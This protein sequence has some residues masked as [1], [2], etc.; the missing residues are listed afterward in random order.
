LP[1]TIGSGRELAGNIGNTNIWYGNNTG[2]GLINN[3]LSTTSHYYGWTEAV[4][5]DMDTSCFLVLKFAG[6]S[7]TDQT[8]QFRVISSHTT[9]GDI[10]YT[11]NP[12]LGSNPSEAIVLTE[13]KAC[14]TGQQEF[15]TAVLDVSKVRARKDPA[16]G[17]IEPDI[18]SITINPITIPGEI[19]L[20]FVEA[21]YYK[22]CNGGH[23]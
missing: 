12:V 3:A 20:N 1:L 14:L 8:V 9:Q 16:D 5:D 22:W 7:S 2:V 19:S 18:L 17:N 21:K 6:R 10:V 15:F 23:I 4:P 11:S 13:S